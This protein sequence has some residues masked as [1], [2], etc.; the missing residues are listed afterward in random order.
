MAKLA[1]ILSEKGVETLEKVRID[2]SKND[3]EIARI[4]FDNLFRKATKLGC[5]IEAESISKAV[6]TNNVLQPFE[7]VTKTRIKRIRIPFIDVRIDGVL[8]SLK[9]ELIWVKPVIK[10]NRMLLFYNRGYIDASSIFGN[11]IN[12]YQD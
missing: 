9:S 2:N 1:H 4:L 8:T 6:R 3:H 7:I 5:L 10:N 12:R 11:S